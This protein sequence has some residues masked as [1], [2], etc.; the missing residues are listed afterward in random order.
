[1]AYLYNI[2]DT[3]QSWKDFVL[4]L[5]IFLVYI[6]TEIRLPIVHLHVNG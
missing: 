5:L 3:T 1:M 4:I 2:S 6:L